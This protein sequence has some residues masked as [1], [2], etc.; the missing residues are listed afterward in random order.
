VQVDVDRRQVGVRNAVCAEHID[1]DA[2]HLAPVAGDRQAVVGETL[3]D[4]SVPLLDQR[5]PAGEVVQ[6]RVGWRSYRRE[7]EVMAGGL[8]DAGRDRH[9]R[10]CRG[11]HPILVMS[12]WARA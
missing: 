11:G 9:G 2:G 7:R 1:P 8:A 5:E 4:G 6:R 3:R 12:F 10:S